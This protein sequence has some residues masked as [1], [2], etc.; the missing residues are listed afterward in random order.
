MME[1]EG[2]LKGGESGNEIQSPIAVV[3]LGGLLTATVLNLFVIPCVSVD[4]GEALD[5]VECMN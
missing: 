3:I 2:D 4:E 1:N 5:F